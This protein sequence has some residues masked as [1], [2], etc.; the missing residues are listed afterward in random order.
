MTTTPDTDVALSPLTKEEKKDWKRLQ[1]VVS[2]GI[3]GQWEMGAALLEIN[4]RKL[5]REEYEKFGDYLRNQHEISK[6]RGYQLIDAA[7]VRMQLEK[8]NHGG[9]LPESERQCRELAVVPA[10]EL[11][12]VWE[13][14]LQT[15]SEQDIPV[16]GKLIRQ[17][18][19]E[20]RTPTTIDSDQRFDRV[21]EYL[22][23]QIAICPDVD[24]PDLRC[25]IQNI[26]EQIK[27][28]T[29]EQPEGAE[30]DD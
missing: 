13:Q 21:S 3:D 6:S 27:D 14:V 15:A 16:T 2:K 20:F 17:H 10:D 25:L 1:R 11:S 7:A 4:E 28:P 26:W 8:V 9:H 29:A 12:K 19:A 5:Y 18:T 22:R 23:R 30:T 24:L